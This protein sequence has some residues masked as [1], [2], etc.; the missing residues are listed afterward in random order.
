MSSEADALRRLGALLTGTEAED[1]ADRLSDGETLS[2]ALQSVVATRRGEVR[3]TM[4]AA[5][6]GRGSEP[7]DAVAVLLAVAGAR[8]V[9]TAITPLWTMPGHIAQGGP[10]TSSIDHLVDGATIS[11]TCATFNFQRSSLLWDAL[12]RACERP[13]VTVKVYMDAAASEGN[14]RTPTPGEVAT[15]LRGATV[16]RSRSFQGKQVRSHAKFIAID[17]RFLLT[18]S[19]NFSQSAEFHNVEFGVRVDDVAL[20]EAVERE[21]RIAER[22]LYENCSMKRTHREV[23]QAD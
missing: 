16:L 8:S 20:T 2:S 4:R 19:A 3:A 21:M 12:K 14:A 15:H 17:H 13:G 10:L 7:S 23:P 5:G 11:V 6:M 22:Q 1:L 9:K 18:T